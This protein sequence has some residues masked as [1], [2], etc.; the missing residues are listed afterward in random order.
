MQRVSERRIGD[1]ILE[2]YTRNVRD[3]TEIG[4]G[5]ATMAVGDVYAV[6]LDLRDTREALRIATKALE[7]V[8]CSG[9]DRGFA[10]CCRAAAALARIRGEGRYRCQTCGNWVDEDEGSSGGH[11]VQRMERGGLIPVLCGPVARIR[12]EGVRDE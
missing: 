10:P 8:A 11:T 3:M 12:G 5:T 2:T 6:C 4:I 7:D 1:S 9:R